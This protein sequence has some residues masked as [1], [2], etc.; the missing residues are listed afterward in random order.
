MTTSMSSGRAE[1]RLQL[2]Q[3]VAFLQRRGVLAH[4]LVAD[5]GL[6]QDR[7]TLRAQRQAVRA[8]GAA[9]D[10]YRWGRRRAP[11]APR[12]HAED[13]AGIEVVGAVGQ[14]EEFEVADA[15]TGLRHRFRL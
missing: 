12:D 7:L 11:S 1:A 15:K 8:Q 6:D 4:R 14:D 10:G 9:G 5:A 2:R 3:Q 13:G